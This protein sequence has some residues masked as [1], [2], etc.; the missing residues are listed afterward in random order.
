MID[1]LIERM[2]Q[3]DK[4]ATARLIT[5]VEN[6][7]DKAREVIKKIYPHT[8]NAY[9]VGITGPPG[10]GKSTLLDKLI[11][12]AREEGKVVG[13]IAID[14]TSPFTGGALLGDRIR[15]QRHSTDPGVFIRSMATRGSLGGLAKATSDAIKVLDAY[16]CDVIFVET[17]GVGQIEIDI[18]KTADTVVLVTVPGLGD[19]IQAIKAGLMEIADIFVINKADKEGADATYFELN[20]MLDLEKERWEKRGW[21]PPIVE[22][23][24]TTMRGIRDLWKAIQDHHEFLE[25]SGEIERKRKFRAEEEVKTIISG[26]IAKMISERLD[27]EEV[28]G[29][30]DRIVKR[31]I[32]PYSAADL[33]LEKTLGVRV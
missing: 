12:V 32:D 17:V 11:R 4:R 16:G 8:G 23:V 2:L 21:R 33:V 7:E 20:M 25:R 5:L 13:V 22:T 29:L 15:M 26:R 31:E 1:D 9:I 27:E 6:D 30:I 14:P 19:D 10:A 3:G 18:V 24:A 28:S